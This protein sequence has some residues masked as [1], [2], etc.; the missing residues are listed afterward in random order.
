MIYDYKNRHPTP[1]LPLYC[2][3]K[4]SIFLKQLFDS[5][6]FNNVTS[7]VKPL[8][9]INLLQKWGWVRKI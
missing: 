5:L 6:A 1:L 9:A 2:S 3:A 7:V 8:K 4:E